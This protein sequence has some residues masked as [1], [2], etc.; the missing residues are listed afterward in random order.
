MQCASVQT[1]V[2]W[3]IDFSGKTWFVFC[4]QGISSLRSV[5][6]IKMFLKNVDIST[7]AI[8]N[9]HWVTFSRLHHLQMRLNALYWSLHLANAIF[10]SLAFQ[11]GAWEFIIF[12]VGAE[13]QNMDSWFTLLWFSC[14]VDLK[15]W[16]IL[17]QSIWF[18][19]SLYTWAVVEFS[20][21]LYMRV[22]HRNLPFFN[23][24]NCHCRRKSCPYESFL[25]PPLQHATSQWRTCISG[26]NVM[27]CRKRGPGELR[28]GS[29]LES[30]T[31]TRW[32]ATITPDVLWIIS[33]RWLEG[34][35]T[36]GRRRLH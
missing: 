34:W 5:R 22:W 1:N 16:C 20:L 36:V 26:T 27:V 32:R 4:K 12:L 21:F 24:E 9:A 35:T 19:V 6:Q 31:V 11:V 8:N 23:F 25:R 14:I 15:V 29:T 17:S 18:S 2:I 10:C 3:K 30:C 28:S 7:S 13:F 33:A